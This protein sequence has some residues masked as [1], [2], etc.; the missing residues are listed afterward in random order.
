MS[1]QGRPKGE[2]RPPGGSVAAQ[3]H[4]WGAIRPQWA[5]PRA[6]CAPPGAASRAQP[7]AWGAIRPQGRPKRELRPRGAS[8]RSRTRGGP[9]T[10]TPSSK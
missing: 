10:M 2:L 4:A 7:H 1:P 8:R 3:P 6:N 5:A 9:H